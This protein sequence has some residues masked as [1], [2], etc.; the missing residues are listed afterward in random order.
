MPQP[1]TYRLKVTLDSDDGK[2][3]RVHRVFFLA[4]RDNSDEEEFIDEDEVLSVDEI[5]KSRFV[6]TGPAVMKE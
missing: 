5:R 1:L 6:L 3:W 2:V 4:K